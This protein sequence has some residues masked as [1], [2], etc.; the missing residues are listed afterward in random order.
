MAGA[1]AACALPAAAEVVYTPVHSKINGLI[2][3]DLNHDGINDFHISSSYLSGIGFLSVKP[4]FRANRI[5]ATHQ[6][7]SGITDL[8]AAAL[9][10]GKTIGPGIP[11][12][13]GANCMAAGADGSDEGPWLFVKGRYLGFAFVIDGKEHFGWA[14]LNMNYFAYDSLGELLGFAYETTPNKPII[15]GD[16][17]QGEESFASSANLG[18]LAAGAPALNILRKAKEGDEP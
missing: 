1:A 3:L 5:V 8:A 18:A 9:P 15:A 7:C 6:S 11:F 13:A 16:K 12:Q 10:V 2:E 17:G 4:N 14:R